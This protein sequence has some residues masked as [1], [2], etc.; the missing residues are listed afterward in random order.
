MGSVL[1]VPPGHICLVCVVT[2]V[3]FTSSRRAVAPHQRGVKAALRGRH[4]SLG[5]YHVQVKPRPATSFLRRCWDAVDFG[6]A[7]FVLAYT[8][9]LAAALHVAM[10]GGL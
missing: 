4:S 3:Q 9:T 6:F 8:A 5:R 2:Q 10:G 7:G 1:S